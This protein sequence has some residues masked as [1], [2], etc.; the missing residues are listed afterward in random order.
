MVLLAALLA[1]AIDGVGSVGMAVMALFPAPGMFLHAAVSWYMY[2]GIRP[3]PHMIAGP[4]TRVPPSRQ[5]G[6]C[7]VVILTAVGSPAPLARECSSLMCFGTVLVQLSSLVFQ[8]VSTS[9]Q[10]LQARR[11]DL[12]FSSSLYD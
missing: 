5:Q 10:V 6:R 3:D 7:L 12:V 4:C 11:M 8:L 9:C 2:P 1:A